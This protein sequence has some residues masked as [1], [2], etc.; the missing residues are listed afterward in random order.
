[1][2]DN[3]STCKI[4]L[5]GTDC[6]INEPTPFH[7]MWYSH[8]FKGPGVRYEIGLCIQTGWIV[9][10][11]GPYPCGRYPDLTIARDKIQYCMVPGEKYVAD[12]GYRDAG[13]FGDTPNGLNNPDQKMKR[14]A[15]ARHETVNRRFKQFEV[16]T[17]TFRHPLEKHWQCFHAIVNMTQIDMQYVA[18]LF[19]IYYD[20]SI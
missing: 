20:D 5:D 2:K 19:E 7:R 4:T 11:N 10:K 17:T 14:L 8:K 12:G 9:W 13:T 6:P 16:L 15:R 3:G 1:M 18:P